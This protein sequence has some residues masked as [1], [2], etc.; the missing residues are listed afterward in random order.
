MNRKQVLKILISSWFLTIELN[1]KLLVTASPKVVLWDLCYY[2][3]I[4]NVYKIYLKGDVTLYAND[5]CLFYFGSSIVY[6][7]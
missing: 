5:T 4:N 7:C 1:L 6:C 3:H 2:I